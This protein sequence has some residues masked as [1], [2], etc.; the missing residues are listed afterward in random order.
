MSQQMWLLIHKSA[1][2][3]L[4]M[5][6]NP[7]SLLF[8]PINAPFQPFSLPF[9]CSHGYLPSDNEGYSRGLLLLCIGNSID[10]T[11]LQMN[12]WFFMVHY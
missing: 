5:S 7:V 11:A 2:S 8:N 3:L 9:F 1:Q 12:F 6:F 4:N 10:R